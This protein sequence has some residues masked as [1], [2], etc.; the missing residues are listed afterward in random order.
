MHY[1]PHV[2]FA[3]NSVE[4]IMRDVNSGWA[5][6]YTHANVAS[7][8][9]MFVY[10]QFLC[11]YFKLLDYHFL[12]YPFFNSTVFKRII[13]NFLNVIKSLP[14]SINPSNNKTMVNIQYNDFLQWF[15]G[16]SD[17]E[18]AFIINIKN[19]KEVH[20][21]FQITLHIED[22]AV[23]YTIRD[24]LGIG[25]V[26]IKG[27]TCSFR[28]HSFQIIIE[29]LLPLFDKYP[30]L[31]HNQL[32]YRDWRKA[33][34]LKKSEQV[35]SLSINTFNKIVD[36]KKGM[37]NFRTNYEGYI[38]SNDMINKNW[39]V[40][41]VEG[42]GSFNFSNSNVVFGITQKDKKILEEIS[43]FLQN[44]PLSPPFTNLII[45]KKPYCIIKNNQI[46]Y[47]LVITDID[48]L[49]Q[50]IYPFFRNLSFY[51]RKEIDFSIWSLVLYIFIFGYNHLPKGKELLLKLSNNKNSK[52]YFSDL[53]DFIDVEEI[54]NLFTM[55]P[56]YRA[57]AYIR[58]K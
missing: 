18:A 5:V 28:V 31:T 54:E 8:F 25:I 14:K 17:A 30:L 49:F 42:D 33:I 48:V 20:F 38:L 13:D 3:F 23:L 41:F 52:R 36:L 32:N 7:F 43:Y 51:S 6:R 1:Q 11:I 26:S 24:K 12:Y 19:N 39:L 40:G 22:V 58:K 46:A 44:V 10:A 50:Y 16:F 29:N 53:S 37:N 55:D 9:F 15:V 56:P 34:L 2:D 45:P 21:V 4:H 47:Q 35:Q 57:S 27:T